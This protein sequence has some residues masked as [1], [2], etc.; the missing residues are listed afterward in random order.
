MPGHALAQSQ[1]HSDVVAADHTM[2]TSKLIGMPVFNQEGKKI[3]T[4]ADIL[5]K[6][7]AS[8]PMAVLSVGGFTGQ[9]GKMVEVPLSHVTVEG[10]KASMAGSKAEVIAMPSWQFMGLGGGGG[11]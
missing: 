1:S 7:D 5:V 9:R 6:P 11:G 3:G 8:E 2:R 4:I 10:H